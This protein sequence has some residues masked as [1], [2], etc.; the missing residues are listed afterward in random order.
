MAIPIIDDDLLW[1]TKPEDLARLARF[2]GVS[3]DDAK[4]WPE[5]EWHD[6]LGRRVAT[7]IRHAR[8]RD[9]QR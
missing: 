9:A 3:V 2:V 1:H 4:T 7:A 5:R 8:L 6:V